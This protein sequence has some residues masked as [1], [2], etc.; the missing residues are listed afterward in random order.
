MLSA[1]IQQYI[2]NEKIKLV[3]KRAVWIGNDE[4]HYVRKWIEK[5]IEDLKRLID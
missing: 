5:D 1:C 2:D 3:S 4:T